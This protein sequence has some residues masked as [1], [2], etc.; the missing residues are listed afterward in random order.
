MNEKYGS[1]FGSPHLVHEGGMN[2]KYGSP[3]GSP[4]IHVRGGKNMNDVNLGGMNEWCEEDTNLMYM[5]ISKGS[6]IMHDVSDSA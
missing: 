4:L 2:E 6:T 1:P 5:K 3:F